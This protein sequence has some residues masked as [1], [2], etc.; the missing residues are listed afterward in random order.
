MKINAAGLR[1]IK[2]QEQLKLDAYICPA[3]K[4]TIGYGHTEGVELGMRISEHQAD[5]VLQHDVEQAERAVLELTRG[6]ELNENQFSA[7]VSFVFNVG[8]WNFARSTMLRR[9]KAGDM[10]GAASEFGRWVWAD[11]PETPEPGDKRQLPGLV[12]RRAAERALFLTP[13]AALLPVG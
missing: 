3:G 7:L 6:V 10:D 1:I 13:V 9:L 2:E 8:R 5:V 12:K 4:P 11:N